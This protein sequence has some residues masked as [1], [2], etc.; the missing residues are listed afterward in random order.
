V[1]VCLTCVGCVFSCVHGFFSPVFLCFFSPV[2]VFFFVVSQCM[3]FCAPGFFLV[4]D[5]VFFR[6][7]IFVCLLVR[8][9]VSCVIMCVLVRVFCVL[10]SCVHLRV[11]VLRVRFGVCVYVLYVCP[12]RCVC[13]C[14]SVCV[15]VCVRLAPVCLCG[16]Y[17]FELLCMSM[18]V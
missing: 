10:V 18:G 7:C 15:C 4:G 6:V 16:C 11:R 12:F 1:C 9:F 17:F 5:C 3:C 2:F 13:V 14:G 8:V